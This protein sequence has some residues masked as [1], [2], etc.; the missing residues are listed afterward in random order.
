MISQNDEGS[1]FCSFTGILHI[2]EV[3]ALRKLK[4]HPNILHM[5]ECHL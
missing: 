3:D 4:E 1:L 5:I 2:P